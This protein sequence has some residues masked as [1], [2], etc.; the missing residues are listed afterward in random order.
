MAYNISKGDRSLGDIKFEEDQDTGIDFDQD[1][2]TL[3][4][5]ATVRL[6][7][8]NN[9]VYIPDTTQNASLFVSGGIEVTPGNQEGLR[10]MKSAN[11]LNFISFQDGTDGGS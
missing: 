5:N 7:V 9:G 4:T 1:K 3:E 10:F 8:D 11:E 6:Q 2:I